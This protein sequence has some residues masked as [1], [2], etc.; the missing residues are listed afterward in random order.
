MSII[1]DLPHM[2]AGPL[3]SFLIASGPAWIAAKA[4]L[5]NNTSVH[6]HRLRQR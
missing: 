4:K 6:N 3:V 5:R 1:S 2:V